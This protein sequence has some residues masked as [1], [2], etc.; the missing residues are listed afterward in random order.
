MFVLGGKKLVRV[1]AKH[2]PYWDTGHLGF[3]VDQMRVAGAPEIRVVEYR[4]ELYAVEGSHRLCAAHL[5][6][7]MPRLIVE[8]GERFDDGGEAFLDSLRSR[9]PHYSWVE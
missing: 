3:V 2:E 7:L 9:L 5:L 4:G 8:E 6:G 1:F